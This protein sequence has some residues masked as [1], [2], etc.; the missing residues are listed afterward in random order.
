[1]SADEAA[2]LAPR[3]RAENHGITLLMSHL[4]CA[5]QQEHPLNERQ[6][7]L[8]REA[9]LL[10]RGIP[11]SLANSSGIFLGRG[12]HCDMVRPGAALF[13]VNPMP[14]HRNPMRPVIELL[15]R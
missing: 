2:A 14:G 11:A 13:G 8:F 7:K 3:I 10:Y 6:M 12:A 9:R 4:V 15:A 1:I 5:D